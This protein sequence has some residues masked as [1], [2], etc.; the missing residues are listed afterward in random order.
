MNFDYFCYLVM[1]NEILI[2]KM[3]LFCFNNF[4]FILG[5]Y[6]M[7]EWKIELFIFEECLGKFRKLI[8]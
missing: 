7:R 1:N 3:V 5:K 6:L 4:V 8:D 2:L